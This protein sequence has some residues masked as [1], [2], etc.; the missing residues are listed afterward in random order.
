MSKRSFGWNESKYNRFIKENRGRG[1]G[2]HYTPWLKI[3]DFPSRGRVSRV[4]GIKT[5]RVHSLF[6]DLE[7]RCFYIFDW[8][9]KEIDIREQFPLLEFEET[10]KIAEKIGI[11]YPRDRETDFPIVMTTDFLLTIQNEDGICYVA[12]TVKPSSELDK[13]RVMEKFEIERRYWAE[14]NIDW[15]I[16]TEK[17]IQLELVQNIQWF[18]SLYNFELEGVSSSDFEM[19]VSLFKRQFAIDNQISIQ[20]VCNSFDINQNLQSGTSMSL[21]RYLV[22]RKEIKVNIQTKIDIHVPLIKFGYVPNIESGETKH[23]IR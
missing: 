4:S 1:E 15:G 21:F 11:T 7:T 20:Q 23:V 3:Q 9:N 12:R 10:I 18:Q 8:S 16:V 19:L 2:Y 17:E 5:Q 13:K 14:R 6:S 22:A